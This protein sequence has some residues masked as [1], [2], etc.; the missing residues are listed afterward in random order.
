MA[1]SIWGKIL[2]G[3]AGFAMGG[4]LGAILGAVAGHAIDKMGAAE[5]PGYVD[6]E[7][8]RA[9]FTIGVIVL[10]AKMAKADGRVTRDEVAAFKRVFDIPAHEFK[11][12]GEMFDRA[13]KEVGGFEPYARQIAEMFRG[14]P[15]VLEEL[16]GALFHIAGADRVYHPQEKDYLRRV[17]GI[18]GFNEG[19]FRRIEAEFMGADASDPYSVL[20]VSPAASDA[21][22]KSAYRKLIR[23][24][25][26]DKLMAEGLP[27]EFVK[28]AN[29]KMAAINAAYDRIEKERGLK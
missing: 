18:F 26:P 10:G 9:A 7:T 23:E 28:L 6:T 19:A 1:M 25:H 14:Q 11:Q 5:A 21:D 16:L 4:P 15:A 13:R 12:V 22:I 27:E 3:A 8:R 17:A 24:N 2:G 20:G 29:E